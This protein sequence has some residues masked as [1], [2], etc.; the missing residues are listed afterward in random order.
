MPI[1][2]WLPWTVAAALVLTA[3]FAHATRRADEQPV[4][5][6]FLG[7]TWSAALV[8]VVLAGVLTYDHLLVSEDELY[9]VV[10]RAAAEL[11][12]VP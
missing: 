11:G 7:R 6:A 4:H 1:P 3:W 2:L 5:L 9:D 8:A 12:R 10:D